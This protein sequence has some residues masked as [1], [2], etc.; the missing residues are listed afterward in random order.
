MNNDNCND[1]NDLPTN[2]SLDT[3][4]QECWEICKNKGI[5]CSKRSCRYWLKGQK[6]FQNCT[7]VA[8]EKGPWTLQKVGEFVG[9]TRMRVCQIEK[10]A[11]AKIEEILYGK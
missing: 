7:L 6:E 2:P 11:I 3:V 4:K 10:S 8:A 9:L 5:T 1:K